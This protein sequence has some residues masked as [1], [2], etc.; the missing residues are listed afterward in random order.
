MSNLAVKDIE[1]D[2]Y[3]ALVDEAKDNQRSVAAEVRNW[4]ADVAKRRRAKQLIA[5]LEEMRKKTNWTLPNG[6]TSLDLL[7][8]ER[9]SR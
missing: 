3:Q 7:R 4:V 5:E 1:P 2:H 9:D 8:E 6:M